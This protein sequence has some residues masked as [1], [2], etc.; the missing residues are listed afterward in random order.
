MSSLAKGHW[1]DVR[2]Q[3]DKRL[4]AYC[5][6]QRTLAQTRNPA[7]ARLWDLASEVIM[8]GGKRLRPYLV[9]LAYETFG[10]TE[11]KKIIDTATAWE[12][13][14]QAMLMHDDIIDR[15]YMRHGQLNVAGLLQKQYTIPN[16]TD[17]DHFA[18]SGALLAGD[19]ALSSAYQLFLDSGLPTPQL[20]DA[21]KA[22]GTSID[23]VIGGELL[24]TEAVMDAL[25]TTDSLLIAELKTAS[26]SFVGPLQSGAIL[27]GASTKDLTLLLELGTAL[28]I[29]FQLCDDMLGLFGDEKVTGKSNSGDVREGKRTLLLQYTFEAV[30]EEQQTFIIKTVGNPEASD[31]DVEAFRKLVE[32]TG[33]K[34]K[35][36]M[37]IGQ[38]IQEADSFAEKLAAKNADFAARYAMLS[39][40]LR[41]R[42]A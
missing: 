35:V 36:E 10:G 37:L 13:L 19:L 23:T 41:Q 34:T 39:E 9:V 20:H 11:A 38:Y 29:A 21:L 14:H 15:D 16:A 27:A 3:V 42:K 22:F 18:N 33:A 8:A 17:R 32:S 26:Y 2:T 7:E 24:D 28:G 31:E 12:M 5:H 40:K 25:G 4:A 1:S 30:D 6:D